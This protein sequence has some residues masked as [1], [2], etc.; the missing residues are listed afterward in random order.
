MNPISKLNHYYNNDLTNLANNKFTKS[1]IRVFRTTLTFSNGVASYT[2]NSDQP[3]MLSVFL[4]GNNFNYNVYMS[5]GTYGTFT[6]KNLTNTAYNG[7]AQFTICW[8][9]SRYF[10]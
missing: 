9:E 1:K 5:N 8:L 10:L 3:Y 6:V 4:E 2:T 7:T